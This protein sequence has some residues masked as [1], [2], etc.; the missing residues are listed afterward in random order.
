MPRK[1]KF[2]SLYCTKAPLFFVFVVF[3]FFFLTHL[4]CVNS[5]GWY[6]ACEWLIKTSKN[7]SGIFKKQKN[8]NSGLFKKKKQ[9]TWFQ[10]KWIAVKLHHSPRKPQ[11]NTYYIELCHYD[12]NMCTPYRSIHLNYVHHYH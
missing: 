11:L 2:E 8:K 7:N 6:I 1:K 5:M 9:I 4:I 3:F 10:I 12:W